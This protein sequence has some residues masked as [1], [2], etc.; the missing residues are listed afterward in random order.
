MT[1]EPTSEEHG[2]HRVRQAVAAIIGAESIVMVVYGFVLAIDT[3][4]A[5]RTT[6]LATAA[7]LAVLV[8]LLGAGVGAVAVGVWRGQRWSRSPALVWQLLQASLALPAV[9]LS[10]QVKAPLLVSAVLV[11]VG[12]FLPGVVDEPQ[13]GRTPLDRD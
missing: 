13:D 11:G 6:T 12:L 7:F 8:V 10:L 2:T 3:L 9:G 5:K 4:V 1:L